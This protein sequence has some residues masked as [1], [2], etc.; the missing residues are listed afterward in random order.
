M[1]Q[2]TSHLSDPWSSWAGDFRDRRPDHI[3]AQL[4]Q[5]EAGDRLGRGPA[6]A[7]QRRPPPSLSKLYQGPRVRP[8]KCRP[9]MTAQNK[10]R[11][12]GT[13]HTPSCLPTDLFPEQTTRVLGMA[14]PLETISLTSQCFS[15]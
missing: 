15:S 4:E 10:M 9:G 1:S 6:N 3:W 2:Q 14:G 11:P 13:A 5:P 12:L 7:V 8:T